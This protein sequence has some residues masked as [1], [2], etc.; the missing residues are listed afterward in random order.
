MVNKKLS[1]YDRIAKCFSKFFEQD[2]LQYII[3][4]KADIELVQRLQDTKANKEEIKYQ[5]SLIEALNVRMKHL[6]IILSEMAKSTI[7][8]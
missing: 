6:S 4:R 5:S 7:P 2:E 8:S 1:E 3:E